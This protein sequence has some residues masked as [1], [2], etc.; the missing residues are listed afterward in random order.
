MM[1]M[2][3]V[4]CLTN[5]TSTLPN[6]GCSG[7]KNLHDST[8]RHVN[9]KASKHHDSQTF[10]E[11]KIGQIFSVTS[12]RFAAYSHS[13]FSTNFERFL[14]KPRQASRQNP[15]ESQHSLESAILLIQT[16]SHSLEEVPTCQQRRARGF[17]SCVTLASAAFT[18]ENHNL[19]PWAILDINQQRHKIYP[20]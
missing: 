15:R 7:K 12:E 10:R 20:T 19:P 16:S 2:S 6:E 3:Y 8:D 14:T 13:S 11:R 9:R 4:K 17:G 1:I 5:F 18:T